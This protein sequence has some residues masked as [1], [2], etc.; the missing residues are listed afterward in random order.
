MAVPYSYN[1]I[2]LQYVRTQEF[3]I[4]PW[5]DPT[6]S[7]QMG[8][9][10]TIRVVGFLSLSQITFTNATG[11]LLAQIKE[12]LEAVRKPLIYSINPDQ[13]LTVPTGLDDNLG[14]I[15]LPCRVTEPTSGTFRVET[16]V[17]VYVTSCDSK[18]T[19]PGPLAAVISL[20]WTQ[21]ETFDQNWNSQVKTKGRLIV[22]SS[23]LKSPNDFRGLCT[24]GLL[25]DYQRLGAQYTLSP[26]GLE[27]EFEFTDQE[28][29]RLPPFPSLKA[30]GVYVVNVEP[31]GVNRIGTV[32]LSL[33]GPKTTNTRDLM[34]RAIMMAYSKLSADNVLLGR[35][36]PAIWWG[37]FD[38]DLFNNRVTVRMSAKMAPLTGTNAVDGLPLVPGRGGPGLVP[39]SVMPSAGVETS[40]LRENVPGIA[41]P[42]R[43]R[44]AALLSAAFRDPCACA[45]AAVIPP[46]MGA[47]GE[48]AAFGAG[49]PVSLPTTGTFQMASDPPPPDT[50]D[51]NPQIVNP[52]TAAPVAVIQIA[53]LEPY[54]SAQYITDLAPYD[55]YH[56]ETR[57]TYDTGTVQLPGTG[58][59]PDGVVS[60]F[61]SAS[62]PL[63]QLETTWVAGRTGKPPVLPSFLSPNPNYVPLKGRVVASD[64]T[65]SPD[66]GD[67]VYLV[68]GYYLHGIKDPRKVRLAA[69]LA[70][71][72]GAQIATG[73]VQAEHY[74]SNKPVWDVLG[75]AP[76]G[77]NPFVAGGVVLGQDPAPP[78][79]YNKDP[80]PLDQPPLNVPG[81]GQNGGGG[82]GAFFQPP[83]RQ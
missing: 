25:P 20:R 39:L 45:A 76:A 83:V 32:Q 70:P 80:V 57:V 34:F 7:D 52:V 10:Y 11:G 64:V 78:P 51:Y 35:P 71:F 56:I 50:F 65:P 77:T 31:P 48:P 9:K 8:L 1:S 69:P 22:R 49:A 2:L 4:E 15:P 74:W 36:T 73:A 46:V 54:K 17:V 82:G 72:L 18:C 68:A 38:E 81:N 40:G 24:P 26:N 12:R 44:L 79:G 29:K 30:T 62:G 6:N 42:V 21:S 5:M 61:V 28:V 23:L 59:G 53:S 14:P 58:R 37:Q 43:R 75:G 27:L 66:G 63:M 67:L 60:K 3:S 41:P 19:S 33:E 47:S 55:T 16:G 13:M